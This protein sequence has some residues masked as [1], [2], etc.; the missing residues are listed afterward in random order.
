GGDVRRI[1]EQ[2]AE[3]SIARYRHQQVEIVA[4]HAH[5]VQGVGEEDEVRDVEQQPARKCLAHR[6]IM[7]SPKLCAAPRLK[8]ARAC[9]TALCAQRKADILV[10]G[11]TCA[12]APPLP[13]DGAFFWPLRSG[14]LEVA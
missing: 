2:I 4:A 9:R 12:V 13:C 10:A 7:A 11:A 1:R 3:R 5:T 6:A 8:L 14:G